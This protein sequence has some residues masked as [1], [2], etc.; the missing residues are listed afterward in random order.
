[1]KDRQEIFNHQMTWVTTE[2]E[3]VSCAARHFIGARVGLNA[4]MHWP[5]QAQPCS[6]VIDSTDMLVHHDGVH[7][8][9]GWPTQTLRAV[10]TKACKIHV[11]IQA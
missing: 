3:E 11:S 6:K 8:V 1:M 7:R 5:P 9:A 4:G 10:V 2:N